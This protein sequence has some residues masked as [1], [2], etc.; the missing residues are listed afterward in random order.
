LESSAVAHRVIEVYRD[1]L[2]KWHLHATAKQP[3]VADLLNLQRRL[4]N[5]EARQ[6][7]EA[8]NES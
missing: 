2:R 1:V 5:N 7:V 4:G 3:P 8:E 6:A